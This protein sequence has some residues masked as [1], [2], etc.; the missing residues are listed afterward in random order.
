MIIVY[1]GTGNTLHIARL[2]AA[3][4]D[5][6]VLH[7]RGDELLNPSAVSVGRDEPVIWAFPVYSWGV[8]PVVRRYMRECGFEG[9]A[10]HAVHHALIT[11]GDDAGL[12]GS[13]W[14]DEIMAR[15]LRPGGVYGLQMPNTYVF[16]PGM[17]VDSGEVA[18]AKIR[19]AGLAV[20][21]IAAEIRGN[22]AG[23]WEDNYQ[24]GSFAWLKSQV[25]RPW[26]ERHCMSDRHYHAT[27][28]CTGCGR[29]VSVCPMLNIRLD[30]GKP[31]WGGRCAMCLACYHVCPHHA[32]A[33]KGITKKKGQKRLLK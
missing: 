26:F 20:A 15:G 9:S 16:M 4:L 13:Q 33:Y 31:R 2:L 14:R 1:S 23:V 19:D 6:R 7:L 32:V 17:D 12:T 8:P 11:Y 3:E 22:T 27:H 21:R 5:M 29:C 28:D 24:K 18:E 30:E 10:A 25:I